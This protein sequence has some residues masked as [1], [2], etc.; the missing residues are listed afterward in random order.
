MT[1]LKRGPKLGTPENP[2][3]LEPGEIPRERRPNRWTMMVSLLRWA[4]FL[5][6]PAVLADYACYGL[7]QMG[8]EPGGLLAW[9]LLAL[10]TIPAMVLT[11]ISAI[12]LLILFLTLVLTL[13]GRP[14][15]ISTF[16]RY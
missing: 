14:I 15:Q 6:L 13:V 16:R 7:L 2:E 10:L 1:W 3:I 12:S 5:S 8:K 4:V 11:L 9:V